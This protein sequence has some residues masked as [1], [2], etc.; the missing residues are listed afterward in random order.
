MTT[1]RHILWW[2]ISDYNAIKLLIIQTIAQTNSTASKPSIIN[3]HAQNP[4]QSQYKSRTRF[5]CRIFPTQKWA[6]FINKIGLKL[7]AI[8][9]MNR[10][11]PS[12]YM[13]KTITNSHAHNSRSSQYKSSK[14]RQPDVH[15]IQCRKRN[16]QRQNNQTHSIKCIWKNPKILL[17]YERHRNQIIL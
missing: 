7:I 13:V 11:T 10:Q 1:T 2:N 14:K 8:K 9:A 15:K 17:L 3:S 5:S 12:H 6:Q 4:R 16:S